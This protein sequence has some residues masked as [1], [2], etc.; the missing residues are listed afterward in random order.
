[1]ENFLDALQN[2]DGFIHQWGYLIL[3]AAAWLEGFNSMI[4][5]G[6]LASLGK[7]N[8]WGALGVMTLGHMCSGF[9]WYAVGFFGGARPLE[10]WGKH[11][12][13]DGKRLAQAH[14]YVDRHGGKA[15]LI[16]KFTV[17]LTIAT[18]IIAGV[19]K[20]RLRRFFF[21]NFFGSL[22][23]T[24]I[25]VSFGYLFGASFRAIAGTL[26]DTLRI[27]MLFF[28]FLGGAFALWY[29]IRA[30]SRTRMVKTLSDKE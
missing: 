26:Q 30:L 14:E 28:V 9:S 1:M 6:F 25:T 22:I 24:G 4:V 29:G 2:N 10:R 20:M 19:L 7:L 16:T 5:G 15:I 23:W 3:F 17:G 12:W 18:L 27:I 21:Y 11:M 8:L 13:L